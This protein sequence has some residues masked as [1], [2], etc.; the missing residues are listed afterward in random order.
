MKPDLRNSTSASS[1]LDDSS[2]RLPPYLRLPL[3]LGVIVAIAYFVIYAAYKT[4]FNPLQLARSTPRIRDLLLAFLQPDLQPQFFL[5]TLK[6]VWETIVI[7]VFST[8]LSVIIAYPLSFFAASNV[9]GKSPLARS[10]YYLMRTFFNA[11]RV[12]DAMVL[13]IVFVAGLGTGPFPGVL[14]LTVHSIGVLGKLFSE[15]IEEVNKG[16][17]EAIRATGASPFQTVIFG[18]VPQVLPY[19]WSYSF[20]RLDANMRMSSILGLVGAGG[21]GYLLLQY[22]HNLKYHRAGTILWEIA[23]LVTLFD[24][25]SGWARARLAR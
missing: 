23:I 3:Y 16:V 2:S 18:I 9:M 24:L 21:V 20:Y 6:L 10:V 22:I 13:A 4:E 12:I 11:A 19:V 5:Y 17:V 1:G 15:A 8:V 7:A 14:A 25:L